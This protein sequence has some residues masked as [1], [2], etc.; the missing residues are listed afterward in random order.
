LRTNLTLVRLTV[1]ALIGSENLTIAFADL[2]TF[3]ARL[4]GE[5]ALTLG[6]TVSRTLIRAVAVA[7]LP[8]PSE[9][10]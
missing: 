8:R 10:R 2:G 1:P 3:R 9:M 5:I 7:C 4:A 6:A